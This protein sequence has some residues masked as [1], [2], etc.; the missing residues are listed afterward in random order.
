MTTTSEAYR[1]LRA[2]LEAEPSLPPLR[3]QNEDEDSLG[4][5]ALPD[6]PA[7]FLLTEF[8]TEPGEMVAFGGGRGQNRYRNPARLDIFVFI[9]KG[10]GV[11]HAT[12]IAETAAALYR[13]YRDD[14]VSCFASTV[15]PGGDGAALKPPGLPS[16]VTNYWWAAVEV[17][18]FFD[19]IG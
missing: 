18:L 8:D 7:P 1:A 14:K 15:F 19:Q 12:D 9:P 13:S 2:L 10:W 11:T 5:V 3:W 17:E 16:E 6:T 4:A